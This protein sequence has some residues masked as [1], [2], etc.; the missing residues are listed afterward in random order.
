MHPLIYLPAQISVQSATFPLCFSLLLDLVMK[1]HTRALPADLPF[2]R[3][4][5]VMGRCDHF[6]MNHCFSFLAAFERVNTIIHFLLLFDPVFCDSQHPHPRR[7]MDQS[8]VVYKVGSSLT[9]EN[10]T[11]EDGGLYICRTFNATR[12]EANVTVT[13]YG[14]CC[15]HTRMEQGPGVFSLKDNARLLNLLVEMASG[16]NSIS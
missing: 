13:V 14:E 16:R 11:M 3:F 5:S 2:R 6:D 12:L 7:A 9:I 4:I 1:L 8:D 15:S 10:V